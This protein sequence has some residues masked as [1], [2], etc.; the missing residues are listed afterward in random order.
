[1]KIP[2]KHL[3]HAYPERPDIIE[4]YKEFYT[5]D[6]VPIILKNDIES[7]ET[8]KVG[9][10]TDLLNLWLEEENCLKKNKKRSK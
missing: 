8:Q 4:D 5:Q 3:P 9:G 10:Y 6:T 1:M 7:G 2:E